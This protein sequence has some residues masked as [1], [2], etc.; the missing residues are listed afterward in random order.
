MGWK[1]RQLRLEQS[2]EWKLSIAFGERLRELGV[3]LKYELYPDDLRISRLDIETGA[4]G[5]PMLV[6]GARETPQRALT[7]D[8]I[9]SAQGISW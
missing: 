4:D 6:V 1:R 3:Q 8:W 9:R 7:P 5:T 2:G